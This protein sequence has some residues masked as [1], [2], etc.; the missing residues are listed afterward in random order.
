MDGKTLQILI[1]MVIY[2][3]VVIVIGVL[4]AVPVYPKLREIAQ[5]EGRLPHTQSIAVI[6][7]RG[8]VFIIEY[9]VKVAGCYL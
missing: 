9:V 3:A 4:F 2:M 6:F 7:N 8:A 1:A 5:Q